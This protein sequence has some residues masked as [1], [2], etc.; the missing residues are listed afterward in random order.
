MVC[1]ACTYTKLKWQKRGT[2]AIGKGGV[3]A[4]CEILQADGTQTS[5]FVIAQPTYEHNGNYSCYNP[6]C[7]ASDCPILVIEFIVRIAEPKWNFTGHEGSLD[8]VVRYGSTGLYYILLPIL[9][10][11]IIMAVAMSAF[12]IYVEIKRNALQQKP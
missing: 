12:Y 8:E 3:T 4:G 6:D 10:Y 1:S 5:W 2:E 11:C 7:I 9:I